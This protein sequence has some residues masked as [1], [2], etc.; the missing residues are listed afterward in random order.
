MEVVMSSQPS[1]LLFS[2][3]R[4]CPFQR[5]PPWCQRQLPIL[6][7]GLLTISELLSTTKAAEFK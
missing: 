7:E 4:L 5:P 3:A 1:L 2:G 6:C